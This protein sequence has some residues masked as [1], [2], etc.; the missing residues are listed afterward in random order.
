MVEKTP[1]QLKAIQVGYLEYRRLKT[2]A[3]KPGTPSPFLQAGINA[4]ETKLDFRGR[5][6]SPVASQE[7]VAHVKA[8]KKTHEEAYRKHASNALKA[9]L[10]AA[11]GHGG[12]ADLNQELEMLGTYCQLECKFFGGVRWIP[13]PLKTLDKAMGKT[14]TAYGFAFGLN[15]DL[16]RATLACTSQPGLFMTANFVQKT[17]TA[18]FGMHLLKKEE[19]K[20]VHD[21]G[22]SETGY[23]GWNF[24]VQFKEH[25][26]FSAEVQANTYE[27]LYGKMSMQSFCRDL[28]VSLDAYRKMQNRLRFPGGLGHALYDISDT[29]RAKTT[30]EEGDRARSLASD[31]NDACRDQFRHTNLIELNQRIMDFGGTLTTPKAKDLWKHAISQSGWSA[32]ARQAHAKIVVSSARLS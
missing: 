9:F 11:V 8:E 15:K 21:G 17:C 6:K 13:G 19:Q 7:I 31:Y 32:L 24:G 28:R 5:I 27:L 25:R 18:E 1:D 29:R 4:L 26:A 14:E 22:E 2:A 10:E 20:S 3:A 30:E 23:S 16:V 12:A